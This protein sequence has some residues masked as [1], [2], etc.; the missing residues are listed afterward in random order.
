MTSCKNLAERYAKETS[1]PI[2]ASNA[3]TQLRLDWLLTSEWGCIP[4]GSSSVNDFKDQAWCLVNN[5][6]KPSD[7]QEPNGSRVQSTLATR[8][9]YLNYLKEEGFLHW[10]NQRGLQCINRIVG[11][12]FGLNPQ[13]GLSN[14]PGP[15]ISFPDS[16]CWGACYNATTSS[17]MCFECVN[18]V[19]SSNPS[20]CPQI[21]TANPDD[22]NL[23][24]D[25]ISCH[26]CI[27]TQSTFIPSQNPSD[28]PL[29]PNSTAMVNNMWACITGTV[30]APISTSLIVIL[31]VSG[32]F[33]LTLA[34]TLG[35][36]YGYFHP[37]I[38]KKQAR[39]KE[40]EK[41]GIDPDTL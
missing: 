27:G 1:I 23:I 13:T 5:N 6:P 24:K 29:T 2:P 4:P 19:L 37:R 26:E 28:P 9:P 21:N 16:Q 20:L 7:V 25:S 18:S 22:E 10:V 12:F 3:D 41:A 40:L 11:N 38:L 30:A 31:V 8:P 15:S 33:L 32:V 39:E 36:Y 35:L 34:L 17:E 14:A